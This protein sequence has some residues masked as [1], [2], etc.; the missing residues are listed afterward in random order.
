MNFYE[1]K[2]TV[3]YSEL[4]ILNI[5]WKI[6]NEKYKGELGELV[7]TIFTRSN[8][9]NK[10]QRV[11]LAYLHA[12]GLYKYYNEEVERIKKLVDKE[13]V[14]QILWV[15]TGSLKVKKDWENIKT[16]EIKTGNKWET[17]ND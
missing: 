3:D 11:W 6:L 9:L 8:F 1:Q 13:D 15:T 10:E 14:L 4:N 17:Y 7:D 12:L 16:E 2:N 5:E